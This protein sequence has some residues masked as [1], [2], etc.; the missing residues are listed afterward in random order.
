MYSVPFFF[1][2]AH[3]SAFHTTVLYSER[4]KIIFSAVCYRPVFTYLYIIQ[5]LYIN[6]YNTLATFWRIGGK[7]VNSYNL[8]CSLPFFSKIKSVEF[9][10]SHHLLK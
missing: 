1:F 2:L 8:I 3:P 5:S 10:R 9:I 4:K 7:V 6:C